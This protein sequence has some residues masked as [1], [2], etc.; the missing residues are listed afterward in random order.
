LVEKET[1]RLE[2]SPI[3]EFD[4]TQAIASI[5]SSQHTLKS[6]EN[7][8]LTSQN[9][10]QEQN[11]Y[12]Y[13]TDGNIREGNNMTEKNTRK[14]QRQSGREPTE[15][16]VRGG[17]LASIFDDLM[18]P[19]DEFIEPFF[20]TSMRSFLSD[21]NRREPSFDIQDR[22]DKFIVTAELPGFG[23]DDVEVR[24]NSN[25]LELTAEKKTDD[26]RK[27]QNGTHKQ[28][29]Y[30]Y[31]HRYLTLPEGVMTEKVEGTVKNGVLELKLPKKEG[32]LEEKARRVDLK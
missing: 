31:F 27:E 17:G 18:K 6:V 20:P 24:V 21:L 11:L 5:D 32:K 12:R 8:P 30:S 13:T 3:A 4:L 2:V 14:S 15:L 22:G 23:K 25:S 16:A 29:S 1:G 9:L 19:F 10:P 7:Q 28:R 26:E